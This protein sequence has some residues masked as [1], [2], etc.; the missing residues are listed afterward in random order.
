MFYAY[1]RATVEVALV[2]DIFC[3][4]GDVR[5]L[6]Y[7]EELVDSDIKKIIKVGIAFRGKS[8]VVRK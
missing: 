8:A 2:K 6:K 3:C 1:L 5:E 7:E 4:N